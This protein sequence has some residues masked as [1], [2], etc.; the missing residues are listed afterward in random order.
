MDGTLLSDLPNAEASVPAPP[1]MDNHHLQQLLHMHAG[2]T[3]LPSRDIPRH[4]HPGTIDPQAHHAYIPP[5]PSSSTAPASDLRRHAR[6]HARYDAFDDL[7][8][9]MQLPVLLSAVFFVFQL[10]AWKQAL[11]AHWP[12]LFSDEEGG[13]FT[14]QGLLVNSALYGVAAYS[15][16]KATALVG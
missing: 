16:L 7:F 13:S 6:K 5:M 10:P 8:T 1:K 11:L 12:S 9:Y 14:V 15:V 2:D 3:R 4:T